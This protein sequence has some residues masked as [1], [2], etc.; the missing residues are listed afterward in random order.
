MTLV[1]GGQ[2]FFPLSPS[3]AVF[4]VSEFHRFLNVFL[5]ICMHSLKN[6]LAKFDAPEGAGTAAGVSIRHSST[7]S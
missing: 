6:Q 5:P 7:F 1:Q 2:A 4:A 3:G